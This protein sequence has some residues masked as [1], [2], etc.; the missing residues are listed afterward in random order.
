MKKTILALSMCSALF[1]GAA[2]ADRDDAPKGIPAL[3]HVFVIMM[4]NHSYGEVIGNPNAPFLNKMAQMANLATNYFGVGH[5]SLTN[6]LE[7][8]GG[9]NFGIL[10]DHSPDWHDASCTSNIVS[11]ITANE[12]T[13]TGVCPISGTGMDA[14]T[15]AIDTTNEGTPTNPV[16]NTPI[17]AARTVGMTIADQLVAAGKSWKS[18]QEDLPAD[19]ADLVNYSDGIYSNLSPSSV[20]STG[21]IQS[22]YAVK[23]NPFVYFTSVQSSLDPKNSL[24]NAVGFDGSNG[25]FADLAADN[26]PNFAFIAPD[27]CHDMHGMGN[28]SPLCNYD[29]NPPSQVNPFLTQM[30]DASVKKIVTA[31]KNSDAWKE[32]RSAIVVLWDEND[33]SS[34]PNQVATIVE[35]NYGVGGVQSNNAYNHFSL[36]KTLEAGFGLK[37]LNHACDVDVKVMSD[38]FGGQMRQGR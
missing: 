24:A 37:C 38:L 1:S 20:T 4:E 33:Y 36:L 31:I 9:S 27:Q 8:V 22:L 6:Y 12:S 2:F 18:Y 10:N 16:Y 7:V 11:G 34:S 35:T 3:D 29:P 15:P 21:F 26:V 14:P 30:G 25:L 17:P 5:P 23:H 13:S 32:G 19:G 28:G